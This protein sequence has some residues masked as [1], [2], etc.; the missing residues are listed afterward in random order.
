MKRPKG[1]KKSILMKL[2][3]IEP[4]KEVCKEKSEEEEDIK[5]T[6]EDI[7]TIKPIED[8]Q[9]EEI[10]HDEAREE[11]KDYVEPVPTVR[12]K[13]PCSEKQLAA[14]KRNREKRLNA[15]AE[16]KKLNQTLEEKPINIVEEKPEKKTEKVINN[17]NNNNDNDFEKFMENYSKFQKFEKIVL[18]KNKPKQ[19]R[20]ATPHNTPTYVPTITDAPKV[21]PINIPK[22]IAVKPR[23]EYAF[24]LNRR[25]NRG[26]FY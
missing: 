6:E 24:S 15:L 16:K 11:I 21:K 1:N 13:R 2:P 3:D 10:K 17:N 18:E 7:F 14:L 4:Q 8:N 26:G 20:S 23:V 22:P 19:E 9:A 5:N 12:K 25:K